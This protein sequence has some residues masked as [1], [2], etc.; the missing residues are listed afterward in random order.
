[1]TQ[2]NGDRTL[3]LDA[4]RL[5][6]WEAAGTR[7]QVTHGGRTWTLAPELA[8]QVG[9]ALTRDDLDTALEFLLENGDEAEPFLRAAPVTQRDLTELIRLTYG[10]TAPESP[11]S[12]AS[13]PTNGTRSRPT[14]PKRTASTSAT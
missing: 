12:P 8:I 2:P 14:S 3:D 4:L 1:V 7:P 5:A 9:W 6:R 10:V 13:S 11:A